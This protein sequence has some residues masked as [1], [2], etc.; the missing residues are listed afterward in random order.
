MIFVINKSLWNKDKTAIVHTDL[1]E[2]A[3]RLERKPRSIRRKIIVYDR[4][5][6]EIGKIEKKLFRPGLRYEIFYEG[7]L[8]ATLSRRR[9]FFRKRYSISSADG[10]LYSIKGDIKNFDYRIIEK[11]KTVATHTNIY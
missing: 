8:L 6:V 1:G 5:R 4:Y 10:K 3:L 2:V 11:R 7:K 9:F